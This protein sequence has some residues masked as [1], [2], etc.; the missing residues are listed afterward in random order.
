VLVSVPELAAGG[1]GCVVLVVVEA[2]VVVE[3]LVAVEA[4]AVVEV[5]VVAVVLVEFDD[6]EL[7]HP[8]SA[9][10]VS[11]IAIRADRVRTWLRSLVI[12]RPSSRGPRPGRWRARAI[13][14]RA[15]VSL[16]SFT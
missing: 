8:T 6:D 14:M 7:P 2:L 5:L 15:F 3:V 12:T 11:A 1:A 9:I 4:L 16:P 10:A 13:L